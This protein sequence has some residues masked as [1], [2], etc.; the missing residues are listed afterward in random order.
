LFGRKKEDAGP[1]VEARAIVT[2]IADTRTTVNGNPRV[3]LTLEVQPE[4]AEPWELTQK[5]N[6]S[7]IHIPK[8]G[9]PFTVKYYAGKPDGA[10]LQRRSEAEL[11]AAAGNGSAAAATAAPAVD[12]LER[13]RKLNDLRQ[14]GA[15]TDEEFE[16]QKAKVLADT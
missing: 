12:P 15:L 13:L 6:V 7:R 1:L 3:K 11:A 5:V 8:P 16:Q 4:G 14:A 10:R 2:S 9:D